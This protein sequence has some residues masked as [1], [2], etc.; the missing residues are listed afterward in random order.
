MSLSYEQ[1]VALQ[2]FKNGNNLFITGPGGTGKTRLI[3]QL[4]E[5]SKQKLLP[6]QVCAMTGCASV[7]LNCNA[8]TLH[9]WSGIKLARG[10][11]AQIVSSV[12]K[13][14]NVMANWR[15]IKILIVDEISMMSCKIFEVI[16]NIA[17]IAKMSMLP[18]GGIQVIFT[19][20]FYQL[21]PVGNQYEQDSNKFCFESELWHKVFSLE[22]HIQLKTIFRQKDPLYI[23]ILLQIREGYIS[24]TNKEILKSYVKRE[25]DIEKN[26]G[27]IPSKIFSVKSKVD[28]VNNAMFSKLEGEE[29]EFKLICRSNMTTF[30]DSSKPLSMAQIDNGKNMNAQQIAFEIDQLIT[31]TGLPSSIVLKVGAIVMCTANID[32]DQSICNGSQGI[33]IDMCGPEGAKIP[34]VRFSNDIIKP[35]HFHYIQSEDY[36]NIAIAQIPLTLAWG[37]TIHKIQ[38][39]TMKMAEMDLGNSIFEYGQIYVALSRVESL[40]GL[41]LSAFHAHKIKANPIVKEFYKNIP[42][43]ME[44]IQTSAVSSN[45]PPPSCDESSTETT[46]NIFARF[47]YKEPNT[48]ELS[49]EIIEEEPNHSIKIIKLNL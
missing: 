49:E 3:S 27:C 21:P 38:G 46:K 1:Q 5:W 43:I 4:V 29:H 35:I 37:M 10:S 12:T 22:N 11:H 48:N 28:F 13:N 7:L 31:N 2:K 18:F 41:Y 26:N 9:S 19:G 20:D 39:A 34:V 30:V 16:E 6:Y 40:E 15:K 42:T 23:E 17:R 33:V 36:P 45:S 47:V 24:D 8:R 14:K 44:E 32:M 25:Y